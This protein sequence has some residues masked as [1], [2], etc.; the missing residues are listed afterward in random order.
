M[1]PVEW[2]GDKV[3]ILDQTKLPNDVMIL[4]FDDYRDV[5]EAIRSLQVR[6]APAIGVAAAYG[7]ALGALGIKAKSDL[8]F[9]NELDKVIET[10]SST[11]PTAVNLFNAVERMR[12]VSSDRKDRL[13]TIELLTA[14]ACAIHRTEEASTLRLSQLGADLIQP[15]S[16]ILTH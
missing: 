1:K 14:E 16:T 7:I 8:D 5:A 10:I 2:V 3:R 4:D 11:R 12:T 15:V 13:R 9:F 6:G